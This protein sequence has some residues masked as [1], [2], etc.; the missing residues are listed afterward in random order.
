M[1]DAVL[2]NIPL[3]KAGVEGGIEALTEYVKSSY[4]DAALTPSAF[5]FEEE[6][7]PAQSD[8]TEIQIVPAPELIGVDPA[9]YR[10]IE[11]ALKG[12]KRHLMLYGPP[13][14]GK[15]E[16][17]RHIAGVLHDRWALITGSAD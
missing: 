11:A 15:T 4:S 8:A 2:N 13:G 3:F 5:G 14:T 10:Q 1:V 12:G 16:I 17:S 6:E 9:V 7:A